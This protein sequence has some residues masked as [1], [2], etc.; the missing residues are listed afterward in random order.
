LGETEEEGREKPLLAR[1]RTE[2]GIFIWV[3]R[4]LLGG[5]KN[6]RGDLQGEAVGQKTQ[7]LGPGGDLKGGGRILNLGR[8]AQP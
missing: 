6:R 5:G 1:R 7:K 2:R 3:K 4:G 8:F